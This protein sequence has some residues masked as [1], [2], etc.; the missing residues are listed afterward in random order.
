[1]L[2]PYPLCQLLHALQAARAARADLA[3]CLRWA[4]GELRALAAGRRAVSD[5][6]RRILDDE[7]GG[8][9]PPA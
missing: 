6:A 7:D 3:V 9:K 1:M 2:T 8:D 4:R 5:E